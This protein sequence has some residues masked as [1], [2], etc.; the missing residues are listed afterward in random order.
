[1][2]PMVIVCCLRRE[3]A[4]TLGRYF[5]SAAAAKTRSWVT[6]GIERAA[7]AAV[8]TRETVAM[9]RPRCFARVLRLTERGGACPAL[10]I[11]PDALCTDFAI[12][13]CPTLYVSHPMSCI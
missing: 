9:E 8:R 1:M 3:R 10:G 11:P 5:I 2:T 4:T 6:L 13:K 7:G 12:P